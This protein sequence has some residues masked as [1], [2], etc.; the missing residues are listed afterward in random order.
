MIALPTFRSSSPNPSQAKASLILGPYFANL[1][2][3]GS[4]MNAN[5][6]LALRKFVVGCIT[7]NIWDKITAIVPLAGPSSLAGALVP[8]KGIAPTNFSFLA[9]DHN[10]QTGLIGN[11]STKYLV[12]GYSSNTFGSQNNAH[13]ACYTTSA[14]PRGHFM[15]S[16]TTNLS[17]TTANGVP[18]ASINGSAGSFGNSI[19]TGSFIGARRDASGTL[20]FRTASDERSSTNFSAAPT[21]NAIHVF[22]QNGVTTNYTAARLAFYS[23]GQSLNMGLLR[24]RMDTYIS[25]LTLS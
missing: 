16:P 6:Q 10:A 11:G 8:L 4:S 7:D 18:T 3:A 19:P 5:N 22:R 24:S 20:V 25:E 17:F 21:A 14:T 2:A 15:G 9:G 23:L 1:T 13:I 12:T